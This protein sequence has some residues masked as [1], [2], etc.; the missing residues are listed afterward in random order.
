MKFFFFI[1][2]FIPYSISSYWE[3]MSVSYSTT[4]K[5]AKG[6]FVHLCNCMSLKD[7]TVYDKSFIFENEHLL[8]LTPEDVVCY[9]NLKVFG[10]PNPSEDSCPKFGRSSS[11]CFYKKAISF[12]TPNKL[13]GWN[14]QIMNGDSYEIS[15]CKW[16]Y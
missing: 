2:L 8:T 14:V 11:L 9:F 3:D 16:S 1:I 6:Y 5:Y 10:T 7:G 15:N 4:P 12:F 13:L